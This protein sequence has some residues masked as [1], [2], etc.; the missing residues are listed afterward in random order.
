MSERSLNSK[1]NWWCSY[2][3]IL[4]MKQTQASS[5]SPFE[6]AHKQC[7]RKKEKKE[8][9]SDSLK[10]NWDSQCHIL[11]ER[12]RDALHLLKDRWIPQSVVCQCAKGQLVTKHRAP[13]CRDLLALCEDQ[14]IFHKYQCISNCEANC[15]GQTQMKPFNYYQS[16][17]ATSSGLTGELHADMTSLRN[18]P[19]H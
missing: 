12:V 9:R 17:W 1:T 18:V 2:S 16:S 14:T 11:R 7:R 6:H 19:L 3:R 5:T 8:K 13:E 10:T 4:E 15:A